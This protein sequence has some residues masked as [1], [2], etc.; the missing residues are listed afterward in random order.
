MTCRPGGRSTCGERL[1][2]EG[3]CAVLTQKTVEMT[4]TFCLIDFERFI[5]IYTAKQRAPGLIPR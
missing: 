1:P 2:V 5:T 4:G 3:R